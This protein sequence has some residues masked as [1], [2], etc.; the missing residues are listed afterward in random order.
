MASGKSTIG[1]KLARK[2]GWKFCDTD[3]LIVREHG[4]IASIFQSDG[5][6]VFRRYEHDAIR[7]ALDEPASSVVALG[8]G[9]LTYPANLPLLTRHAYCIFIKVSP[10]QILGRVR[11]SR[12]F[13]P[14]LGDAPTL[15][16]VRELYATRLPA[17][18]SADYT[19]DASERSDATVI[20]EIAGWLECTRR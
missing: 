13:R 10:E 3:S 16:R 14:L 7:V 17:Y 9:A 8:G 20:D 2:L 6:P 5:E 15:D 1:R 4:A 12:E 19:V 18:E 11:R